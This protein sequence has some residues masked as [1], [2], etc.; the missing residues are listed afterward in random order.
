MV[1]RHACLAVLAG[2]ALPCGASA[3][4]WYTGAQPAADWYTGAEPAAA[5]ASWG[6]AIDA[7]AAVTSNSS[8]F[9][10]VSA[11]IAPFGPLDRSG[12]R[13]RLQGL[14]GVYTYPS[15]GG[16]RVQGQQEEG[17]GMVGYEW[18]WQQAALAGY[19]GFNV[20]SNSLSIADP[21]NPV[22]GTG[23]GLKTA[24]DF[25]AQPSTRTMVA[26]YGSYSTLFHAYYARLRAGY[27]VTDGV[28][29]GP[30]VTFLGDDYFNQWRVG[31]HLTGFSVGPVK[32][33]LGAG[34]VY[35]RIQK[36]GYYTSVEARSLF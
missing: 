18:I 3:A 7:S 5:D 31:G 23:V 20:R 13:I 22:Q 21:N 19:I 9:G 27:M 1:L 17:S 35:D 25:Y 6:A 34:Y 8:A 16:K 36:S 24:L 15:Q 29:V 28:Y 33:S 14:A 10:V 11:T 2:V 32:L 4:D 30:E 26:A 12:A